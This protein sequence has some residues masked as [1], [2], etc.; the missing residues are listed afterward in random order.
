[1]ELS[2]VPRQHRA[3]WRPIATDALLRVVTA[4]RPLLSSEVDGPSAWDELVAEWHSGSG[5][6]GIAKEARAE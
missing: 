3:E 6:S 4:A 1:M 5:S 2:A